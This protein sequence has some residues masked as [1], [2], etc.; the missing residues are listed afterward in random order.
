MKRCPFCNRIVWFW[1]SKCYLDARKKKPCH[2]Y[3]WVWEM[4][5]HKAHS[6]YIRRPERRLLIPLKEGDWTL[7]ERAKEVEKVDDDTWRKGKGIE[8]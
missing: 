8:K 6:G 5:K 2:A 3:C 7:Y 4:A 1:Q